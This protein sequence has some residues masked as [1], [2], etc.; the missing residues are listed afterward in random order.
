MLRRYRE[1][2]RQ[3]YVGAR[4]ELR[5]CPHPGCTET[6]LCTASGATARA[7]VVPTVT[8]GAGHIFCHGCG[9]DAD[10][11]PN[12]CQYVRTWLRSARDDAGTA[13]WIRANTRRC[14]KCENNIEK[15]GGCK[16]VARA[17]MRLVR[18]WR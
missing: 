13:Q 14:P 5:F 8:C 16:C 15:A 2:I 3:S 17:S 7:S 10:H 9:L 6:V 4:P 11:R 18:A 1:L 12:V